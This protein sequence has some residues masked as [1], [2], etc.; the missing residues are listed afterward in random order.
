M[1][2]WEIPKCLA[3]FIIHEVKGLAKLSMLDISAHYASKFSKEPITE[4]IE[5]TA[6]PIKFFY[7]LLRE[8]LRVGTELGAQSH[9]TAG[10]CPTRANCCPVSAAS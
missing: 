10:K 4:F 6:N 2:L 7:L 1:L 5:V 9:E 8:F 3:F